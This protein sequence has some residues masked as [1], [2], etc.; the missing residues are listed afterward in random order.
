MFGD[1]HTITNTLIM[2]SS[3]PVGLTGGN[4]FFKRLKL[5]YDA[6]SRN[7]HSL[8]RRRSST[9]TDS[10]LSH[11]VDAEGTAVYSAMS[12]QVPRHG[13]GDRLVKLNVGGKEFQTLQSTLQASPLLAEYCA[14]AEANGELESTGAIFV[15]RDPTHF[16]IILTFLRNKT[17]G[18]AY[19]SK[20]SKFSNK[21]A[22]KITGSTGDNTKAKAAA[23]VGAEASTEAASSSVDATSSESMVTTITKLTLAKHPQ[24]VRL[25]K[26]DDTNQGLLE[27]LFVEAQHYRLVELEHQLCQ[28]SM[29]VTFMSMINGGRNPFK[30]LND[31]FK[32]AR[33][34]AL[35]LAGGGSIYGFLQA[36]LT[37][38]ES[39]LPPSIRPSK[40]TKCNDDDER[41]V[42]DA[43]GK[44]EPAFTA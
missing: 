10:A 1:A 5:R 22:A 8:T 36:E 16:A 24:Y 11:V 12:S 28:S 40:D 21:L 42:K 17:E 25:P 38:M 14:R 41:K 37:W 23:L 34:T 44:T 4:L 13:H 15:D 26:I 39:L 7:R 18:I 9:T 29:W 19:N 33:R 6:A 43:K 32:Q 27:D 2:I 31:M 30:T 3:R 20:Q 35:A